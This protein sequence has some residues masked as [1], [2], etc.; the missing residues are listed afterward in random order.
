MIKIENWVQYI[1]YTVKG[2]HPGNI[3]RQKQLLRNVGQSEQRTNLVKATLEKVPVKLFCDSGAECNTIN[4][5]LFNKIQESCP[6]L[7]VYEDK[8]KIKCASGVLMNCSGIVNLTLSLGGRQS[9]HPFKIISKMFPELIAG[10]K[11]MKGMDIRVNPANDCIKVG[12]VKI[13]FISRVRAE[14]KVQGNDRVPF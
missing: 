4:L 7:I 6:T 12:S 3:L 2:T 5:E 11:L 14:S 10:I 8:S 9:V 13:P 1:L